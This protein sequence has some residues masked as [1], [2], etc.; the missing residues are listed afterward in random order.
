MT[1]THYPTDLPAQPGFRP[2]NFPPASSAK[3]QSLKFVNGYMMAQSSLPAKSTISPTRTSSDSSPNLAHN[4][5]TIKEVQDPT[6]VSGRYSFIRKKADRENSKIA[7]PFCPESKLPPFLEHDRRVLLFSAYYEEDILESAIEEKRI[8]SCEVYFYVEDGTM[9]IIQTKQENSGIFQGQFLRRGRVSKPDSSCFYEIGD[10][11]IG[12]ELLIYNRIFRIVSCNKSTRDYVMECHGWDEDDVKTLPLPRDQF[13]ESNKAKMDRESGVPGVDRKRKTNDL[14]Q[15]MESILGKASSMSDR[16]MFLEC[17]T[18][19]L[20]FHVLWD[21]RE[22]LYGDIQYFRLVYYLADNTVEIMRANAAKSDGMDSFNKL[23]K[24]SKLPKNGQVSDT[25]CYTWNDLAIGQTVNVFGRTML[26]AGCDSFTRQYYL[27]K[28]T[29]LQEDMPLQITEKKFEVKR[30]IPPYNGFGTEEDSLR[31]CTGGLNPPPPKKDLSK[32]RDK[33]GVVLRFNAQLISDKSDDIARRFVVSFFMEDNTIAI[34]EPPVK[35]SGVMGGNFLRR[36][37]VK[38]DNG[39]YVAPKDMYVGNS[40]S[41]VGHR[42]LL[43]NADEFTY[44]LMECD[45][46]T[47]PYSDFS[48]LQDILASKHNEIKS[49]FIANYEGNGILDEDGLAQCCKSIGLGM[50][51][52]ELM[53][54]WRKLDKKGK[55]KVAFTKLL[56]LATEDL[57]G[58]QG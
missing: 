18:D 31:S 42:F 39:S 29:T 25:D 38:Q 23:L 10:L 2:N 44:R 48:R 22:R 54:I 32:M 14:K 51:K 3:T 47:F 46:S 24:R 36:Q 9:G 43:L 27:S 53:T 5:G 21:D 57:F 56:Q 8:H 12:S 16:G 49:Y 28:G 1:G 11:K 37:A 20:C 13:A 19:A 7:L 6:N 52:Q 35:N 58:S 50:N 26:I 33:T 30:V 17:G 45:E 41:I 15:V 55:G 40:V 4:I 34:R